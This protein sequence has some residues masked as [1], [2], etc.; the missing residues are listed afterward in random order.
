MEFLADMLG[1]RRSGIDAIA[2]ALLQDRSLISYSRGEISVLIRA[3]LE[4]HGLRGVTRRAG[5]IT[6]PNSC[7][8]V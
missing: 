5:V 8:V 3:G 6:A 4:R 7:S 2:A 1:V